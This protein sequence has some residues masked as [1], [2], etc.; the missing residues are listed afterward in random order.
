[1]VTHGEIATRG[2]RPK[3]SRSSRDAHKSKL[4]IEIAS[5]AVRAKAVSARW[6]GLLGAG[7]GVLRP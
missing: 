6:V 1:M 5:G 2:L 4:R 3:L 7:Q